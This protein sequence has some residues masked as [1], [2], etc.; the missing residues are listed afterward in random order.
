MK[1]ITH[2]T[3]AALVALMALSLNAQAAPQMDA[4][5]QAPMKQMK[6]EFG[7]KQHHKHGRHHKRGNPFM[8]E[9]MQLGLTLDQKAQL[10]EIFKSSKKE[11][12]KGKRPDMSGAFSATAFDKEAFIKQSIERSNAKIRQRAQMIEQVYAIL[13]PTQKKL[14][15]ENL[16]HKKSLKQKG[17]KRNGQNCNGRG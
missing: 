4:P 12:K 9:I 6:Q 17:N 3:N 8:K 15:K 1:R 10:K 13:N 14:L 5:Q 16:E 2:I 7:G 11:F